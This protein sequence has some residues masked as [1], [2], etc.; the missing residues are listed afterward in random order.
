MSRYKD[1]GSGSDTPAPP[2]SFKIHG[3]DFA[4]RPAIQG[5]VL[6]DL[7]AKSSA[8]ESPAESAKIIGEFFKLVLMPESGDRFDVLASDPDKIID[9]ETLGEIVGW[10]V[11]Q[12]S[13]RP[14]SRPEALP[15]GQ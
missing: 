15:S 5:K 7:V 14:T 10:L 8:E 4:C 2:L 3:E 12:Y 1:F 9:V 13:D 11:E 6:L